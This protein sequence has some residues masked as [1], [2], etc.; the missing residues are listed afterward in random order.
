MKL[1]IIRYAGIEMIDD[2]R[3]PTRLSIGQ[4]KF[5]IYNKKKLHEEKH[6]RYSLKLQ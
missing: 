6:R 1:K 5:E 2:H 3:L 4:I